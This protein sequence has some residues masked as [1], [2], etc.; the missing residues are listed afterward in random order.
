MCV[1]D[2]VVCAFSRLRGETTCAR[3][4]A[5]PLRKGLLAQH[6]KSPSDKRSPLKSRACGAGDCLRCF[7]AGG[8]MF[9]TCSFIH[10]LPPSLESRPLDHTN[11]SPGIPSPA[12][13]CNL[14]F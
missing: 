8:G 12:T 10:F 5:A 6:L 2:A 13:W 3:W 11:G 1:C 4:L 9:H 7:L 14:A